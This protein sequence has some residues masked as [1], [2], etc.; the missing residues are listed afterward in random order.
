MTRRIRI[1]D[2]RLR[3]AL[4]TGACSGIGRAFAERLASLGFELVVVSN[5]PEPLAA[6]A[7]ELAAVHGV[8]VHELVSDLSRPE[9]AAELH[10]AVAAR[11]LTVDVL[12]SN[13]GCFFFGETV[14]GPPSGRRRCSGCTW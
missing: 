6:T 9:A 2:P 3:V 13:A 1:R 10:A 7:R 12:I 8:K 14:D 4:V 11:G 5:R